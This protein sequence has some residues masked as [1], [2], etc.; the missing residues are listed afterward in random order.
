MRIKITSDSTCDLSP[1]LIARHNI[2]I[3]P[4]YINMDEHIYRDGVDITPDDIYAHVAAG[5]ALCTTAAVNIADYQEIFRKY[6]AENDAVI[7]VNISAEFSSS[8]QNACIA[9]EEFDNVYVVDSRNLSTGHG[10]VVLK[11]AEMAESGME[12]PQI[13]EQLQDI[14][15]KVRA[16]F[17]LDTLAYMR[18]GGRCSSVAALGANLLKL[19]PC[20]AVQDGKMVVIKKYRGAMLKCLQEYVHDQLTTS[21]PIRTDR[22]FITDSSVPEGTTET[23]RK[24]VEEEMKFENITMTRAGCTISCHCGPGTLGILFIVE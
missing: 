1:E 4:L 18:K 21:G 5:G 17:V 16:S 8:H 12:I 7:H 9:A 2:S 13:L 11:A 6:G 19:K 24:A 3:V 23:V 22:I 10:H 15:P 20:I 14:I